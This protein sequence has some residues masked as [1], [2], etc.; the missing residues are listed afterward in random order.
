MMQHEAD[1]KHASSCIVEKMWHHGTADGGSIEE[2]E[3][4][5]PACRGGGSRNDQQRA[6][7]VDRVGGCDLAPACLTHH[8]VAL[9]DAENAADLSDRGRIR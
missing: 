3:A 1:H 8:L 4:W 6:G 9:P 7:A 5:P 2:R